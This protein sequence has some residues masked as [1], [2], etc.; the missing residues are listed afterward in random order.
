MTISETITEILR[1]FVFLTMFDKGEIPWKIG[2]VETNFFFQTSK[3]GNFNKNYT[4]K[5][6]LP[7]VF[8][9]F[10]VDL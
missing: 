1:K 3:R 8:K 2:F 4:A 9:H 6:C 10:W 5:I 7:V